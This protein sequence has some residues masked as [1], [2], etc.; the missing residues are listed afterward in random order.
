[1]KPVPFP[2]YNTVL[3]AEGVK[4]VYPLPVAVATDPLGLP[5]LVS[6]WELDEKEIQAVIRTKKIWVSVMG[7]GM[8]PMGIGTVNPFEVSDNN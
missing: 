7:K 3:R 6:C 2:Q 8:M 4:G 5:L 1:M